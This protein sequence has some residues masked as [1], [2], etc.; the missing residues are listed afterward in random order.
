LLSLSTNAGWRVPPGAPVHGRGERT[1]L[2]TE[3]DC[4]NGSFVKPGDTIAPSGVYASNHDMFVFM[5]NPETYI[6]V[7]GS[8]LYRGFFM[9]N[10]EVGASSWGITAFL[11]NGTCSNHIVWGAQGVF[12]LR[13]RH[14]K[15]CDE[16]V[17]SELEF[18]LQRYS[19]DST[20]DMRGKIASAQRY[21]LPGMTKKDVIENL[22]GVTRQ[23]RINIPLKT[24][25]EAYDITER[26]SDEYGPPNTM[27]GMVQG[28][29]QLAQD[30][31]FAGN[32]VQSD[33]EAGK[34]LEVAF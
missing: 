21:K 13:V 4:M 11:F 25:G 26:R 32:R 3:A 24:L 22:F 20:D 6:E 23:K 33:R 12:E 19:E 1:K 30:Q 9:W 15:N 17:F 34:L 29:T 16:R 7:N 28:L 5:L 27:W 31:K 18:E 14:S 8:P 2:A 10:S